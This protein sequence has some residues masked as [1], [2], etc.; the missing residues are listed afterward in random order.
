MLTGYVAARLNA[1][2]ISIGSLIRAATSRLLQ[3]VRGRR[4]A[5]GCRQANQS[6][7]GTVLALG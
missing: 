1:R 7:N 2:P 4:N 6:L 5:V 3:V